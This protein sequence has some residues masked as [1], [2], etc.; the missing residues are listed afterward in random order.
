MSLVCRI[1][2][3]NKQQII[4]ITIEV[5][6]SLDKEQRL[7]VIILHKN[8]PSH[9]IWTKFLS[10]LL[11]P[12]VHLSTKFGGKPPCHSFTIVFTNTQIVPKTKE[13]KCAK[14]VFETR[15]IS[16]SHYPAGVNMEDVNR[17]DP[18]PS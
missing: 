2:F 10:T 14:N 3:I 5:F 7:H 15:K 18:P 8:P 11:R 1:V 12:K 16:L 4:R 6:I 13:R 17:T 9:R